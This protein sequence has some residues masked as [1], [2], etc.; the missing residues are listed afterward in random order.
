[1][2]PSVIRG[3]DASGCVTIVKPDTLLACHC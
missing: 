3:S 1:V 2:E